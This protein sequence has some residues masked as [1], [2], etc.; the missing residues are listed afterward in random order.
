MILAKQRHAAAAAAV[1]QKKKKS[2]L[3]HT[4]SDVLKQEAMVRETYEL[5]WIW[6]I[7]I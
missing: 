3:L 5:Y 4:H 1:E 7:Y 2:T 6:Y